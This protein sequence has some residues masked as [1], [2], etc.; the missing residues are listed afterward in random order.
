MLRRIEQAARFSELLE[1]EI[2]FDTG[3]SPTI[4]SGRGSS[5]V[6]ADPHE[7]IGKAPRELCINRV[8]ASG[9]IV[10]RILYRR[11]FNGPCT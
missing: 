9:R 4:D 5:I 2:E 10:V 1:G 8:D 6:V 11:R 7:P 3:S